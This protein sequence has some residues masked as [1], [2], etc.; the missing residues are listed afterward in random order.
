MACFID[1]FSGERILVLLNKED[2][3]KEGRILSYYT[4]SGSCRALV[5]L[6]YKNVLTGD[7]V[8][9]KGK[10]GGYGYD[11]YSTAV[12]DALHKMKLAG[13]H[14]DIDAWAFNRPNRAETEKAILERKS[15]PY[16]VAWGIQT[17]WRLSAFTGM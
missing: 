7:F 13:T 15:S 17:Y 2:G 1:H 4:K 16:T 9:A 11:K 8:E 5:T 6:Y 10:A 14:K 12:A 3:S